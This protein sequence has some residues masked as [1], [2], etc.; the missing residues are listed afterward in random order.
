LG[1]DLQPVRATSVIRFGD[2]RLKAA[3]K[4]RIRSFK[5]GIGLIFRLD[6]FF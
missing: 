2:S 1:V 6:S 4:S 3:M 5:K